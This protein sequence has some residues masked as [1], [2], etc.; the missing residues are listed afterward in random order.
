MT[1]ERPCAATVT[2]DP[3]LRRIAGSTFVGFWPA[4]AV[5][6]SRSVAANQV[7]GFKY[8]AHEAPPFFEL[9]SGSATKFC[10]WTTRSASD[11][12]FKI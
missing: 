8:D 2:F 7:I 5:I 9:N 10:F 11:H 12:D 6:F 4:P 1:D 3:N